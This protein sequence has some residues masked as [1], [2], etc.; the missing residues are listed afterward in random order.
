MTERKPSAKAVLHLKSTCASRTGLSAEL[1]TVNGLSL[2]RRHHIPGQHFVYSANRMVR[3]MRQDMT[4]IG[5]K[6]STKAVLHPKSACASRT[7]LS[8]ELTTISG[9]SFERFHHV[10]GKHFADP[11]NRIVRQMCQ[12]MTQIGTRIKAIHLC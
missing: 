8:A 6:P 3:Q 1:A 4:Q 2:E 11:A 10:P 5:S 7:G 12:D 9:L